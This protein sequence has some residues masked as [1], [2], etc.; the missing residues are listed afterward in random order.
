[1]FLHVSVILFTGRGVCP[2]GISVQ[3]GLCPGR[4]LS[5]GSLSGGLSV[6]ETPLPPYGYMWVVCILLECILV[7]GV[8]LFMGVSTGVS[9]HPLGEFPP[10]PPIHGILRDTVNKRA[11]RILLECFLVFAGGG[12]F[13]YTLYENN[14]VLPCKISIA[15]LRDLG[16]KMKI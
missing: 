8:C 7:T 11:V 2:G 9:T 3:G 13:L 10:P 16:Q 4:S 6:R 1:M 12:A 15:H 5:R 14:N